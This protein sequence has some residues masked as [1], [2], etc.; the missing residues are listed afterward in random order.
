[1]EP[2]NAVVLSAVAPDKIRRQH[3]FA[4]IAPYKLLLHIAHTG[5]SD[6][7]SNLCATAACV[8]CGR[9]NC[10]NYANSVAASV[11]NSQFVLPQSVPYNYLSAP[12]T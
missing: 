1:M 12:I 4:R 11:G 9:F 8:G 2:N 3:T 10:I 5:G 7:Y 6:V